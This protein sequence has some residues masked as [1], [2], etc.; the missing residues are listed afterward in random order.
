MTVVVFRGPTIDAAT[1]AREIDADVRPPAARGD[2]LRAAMQSP[3]AIGLVDGTF[4]RV[5]SVWHKE[6]LWALSQ[7]IHVFGASSMGALRAAE[8]TDF[9][10]EGVGRIYRNF[11]DG[12]L[13]DDDDVA[14]AHAHEEHDFR[15]L[16]EAM[17][18]L[19]A[20]LARAVE[21]RVI[22]EP[23]RP[24]IEALAKA[25]FYP[26]R[27]WPDILD[28]AEGAGVQGVSALREWL[29]RRRVDQKRADALEMLR[30]MAEEARAGW[31]PKTVDFVFARTN[32]WTALERQIAGGVLDDG[33]A[34]FAEDVLAE[35]RATGHHG[36]AHLGGLARALAVRSGTRGGAPI[37]PRGV[38]AVADDF[39]RER[40][41]FEAS[42]FD[43][44]IHAQEVGDVDSYFRSEALFRRAAAASEAEIV[45]HVI[46]FLR[47]TGEYEGLA[48]RARSKRRALA[49][50][51]LERAGAKDAGISEGA[52]WK[53]FFEVRLGNP[54]PSN[55]AAYARAEQTSEADLLSAVAAEYCYSVAW[56]LG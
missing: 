8:L 28:A 24:R 22:D 2:V 21:D 37:D 10:M 50:H 46:D 18:N 23:A 27:R 26:D 15:A 45:P 36:R 1:V 55:L 32:A 41:L 12:V 47:A 7:G 53:W 13:R 11:R 29:P 3:K 17:V 54:M 56:S 42:Q 48:D 16:S 39:R 4:D 9:G 40:G 52:L 34:P 51:G 43:A 44:W 14:V 5:P 33:P 31:R 25:M 30:R 20:T 49:A 35:L 6:I 38:A 19:R